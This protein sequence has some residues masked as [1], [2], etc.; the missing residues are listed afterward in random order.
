MELI[1]L[2][3]RFS[4]KKEGELLGPL[5][6]NELAANPGDCS[7]LNECIGLLSPTET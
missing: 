6:V 2:L 1:S 4:V 5:Q 7:R 3:M